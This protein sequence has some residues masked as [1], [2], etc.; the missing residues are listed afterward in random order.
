MIR[1]EK[2]YPDPETF[3]P[4]RYLDPSTPPSPVFGWGRRR[5]PG[6]HLAE[7]SIFITIA[8]VLMTFNI[9]VAQDETGKDIIP[10]READDSLIM[11]PRCFVFKLTPRSS[12]HE[13]LIRSA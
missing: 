3:N 13:E 9:G 4:D 7:A 2:V 11:K 12:K 10:K 1:D 5:C 8:S 6:V